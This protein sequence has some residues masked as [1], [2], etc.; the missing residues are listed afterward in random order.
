MKNI[1]SVWHEWWITA[2][3]WTVLMRNVKLMIKWGSNYMTV[4]MNN[5]SERMD[6]LTMNKL[7]KK[8]KL[9]VYKYV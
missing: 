6:E 5:L 2:K 7:I 3:F 4:W 8:V 9:W 1:E